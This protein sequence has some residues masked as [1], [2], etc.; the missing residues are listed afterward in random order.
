M[1]LRCRIVTLCCT[2]LGTCYEAAPIYASSRS[3]F[4]ELWFHLVDDCL[5]NLNGKLCIMWRHI[6]LS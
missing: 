6:K 1:L 5:F 4:F 2:C 3:D